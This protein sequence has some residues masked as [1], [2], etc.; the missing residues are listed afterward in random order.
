[1]KLI[2]VISHNNDKNQFYHPS[3][4]MDTIIRRL[5]LIRQY[6]LIPNTI[7]EFMD[8]NPIVVFQLLLESVLA[9]SITT[10]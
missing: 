8:L 7:S 4:A 5:P 2:E 3:R 1:M 9:E 10:W 6:F